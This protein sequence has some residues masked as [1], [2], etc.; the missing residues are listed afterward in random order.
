M[1]FSNGFCKIG[2][3]EAAEMLVA[4]L[5][6]REVEINQIVFNK[7]IDGFSCKSLVDKS[8]EVKMVTYIVMIDGYIKKGSICEAERYSKEMEKILCSASLLAVCQWEDG[9]ATGA[10]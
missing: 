7:M 10:F 1:A 8:L 9:C 5:Q 2:Q 6:V 3:I 4:D